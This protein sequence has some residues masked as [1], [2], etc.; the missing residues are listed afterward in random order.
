MQSEMPEGIR[1]R[2]ALLS[3][4]DKTGLVDFARTLEKHGVDILSTGGT[5][6]ALRDAGISITEIAEF[7]GSPE[8]FDGRVKTLHPKVHGGILFRRDDPKHEQTRKEHDIPPID[9]V[10]VNLYPFQETVRRPG[11]TLDEAIEQIDIGGPTLL[12]A[13]AKNQAFVA[14][15]CRPELYETVTAELN[16][17]NGCT[18][19]ELRQRLAVEAFRH[20]AEYDSAIVAHFST[21][22]ISH[23]TPSAEFPMECT[24][25]LAG[26]TRT[27]EL[28]Y[29]EN[30][31]Q[32][33]AFYGD[34]SR[35]FDKLHGVELSYNNILDLGAAVE[36]IEEF[37]DDRPAAAIIKHTNPCGVA[38]GSTAIEAWEMALATD[39]DSAF[40]GIAAFNCVLDTETAQLIHPFYLEII[41][42]PDFTPGAIELLTQKKRRRLLRT[43]T[44]LAQGPGNRLRSAAG[45]ILV[46]GA[47]SKHE[48][49]SSFTVVTERQPTQQELAALT[50]AWK[51]VKHLKSN[52]IA[53]AG[54]N[55]SLG[56]GPG[57]TSRVDSARVAVMKARQAGL[58]LTGSV[59]ASDAFFPY[60]DG[61]EACADV[62]ATAAIQPGGA[63]LDDDVIAAANAN[64]MA[65]VFTGTRHF[66]H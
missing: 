16:E 21:A 1:V 20:T 62:G 35:H 52:A 22:E 41:T 47:D 30:G 53:F 63:K 2:R 36:L 46:Q 8:I 32:S 23:S 19:T 57:Q 50:F 4:S 26:A 5:A 9:L 66:R 7:T 42:A 49:P 34:F 13:A 59:V 38:L 27:L 61:L 33:A 3:V 65:M 48:P 44:P 18:S 54:A 17:R 11:V 55:R 56:L 12:R 45:G 51:V 60:P 29:G 31:H 39:K 58:D 37:G 64:E 28:R 6:S 14:V 24:D 40:G 25:L 15:V 43:R 10:V